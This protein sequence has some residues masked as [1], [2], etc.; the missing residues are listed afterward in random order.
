MNRAAVLVL[1]A[2]LSA[3]CGA[4][5]LGRL[6][7]SPAERAALDAQRR[8]GTAA[9]VPVAPVPMRIDGYALRAGGRSTVWVNGSTRDAGAPPEDVRVTP[10]A[11]RPGEVS[12]I[13][14]SR[15]AS[16]RVKVGSTLDAASGEVRDVIG[17]S[18]VKVR[19]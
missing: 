18:Q 11:G 9:A 6:F 15:G 3:P 2:L 5:D 17:D 14:R 4:Q 8:A 16:T 1:A 19:R 7:F 12:V 13:S 10:E